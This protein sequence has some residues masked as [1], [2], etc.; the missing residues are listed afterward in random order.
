L[1]G[2]VCVILCLAVSVEHRQRGDSIQRTFV[3]KLMLKNLYEW[4]RPLFAWNQ[5]WKLNVN[6]SNLAS[7]SS[8]VC[9]CNLG[10]DAGPFVII[11]LPNVNSVYVRYMLSPVHFKGLNACV[12][13]WMR[14]CIDV[15]LLIFYA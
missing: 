2:V 11:L 7:L 13:S 14:R 9:A 1:Y 4:P 5:F 15:Y 12:P 8:Y 10:Y 6:N 3:Q